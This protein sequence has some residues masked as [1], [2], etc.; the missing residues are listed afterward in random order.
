MVINALK[1]LKYKYHS[2]SLIKIHECG[3]NH[4][5]YCKPNQTDYGLKLYGKKVIV[6]IKT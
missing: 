3:Q 4:I 1:V 5:S 6:N 2:L